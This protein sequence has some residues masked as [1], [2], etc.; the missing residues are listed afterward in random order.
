MTDA[1]ISFA[2]VPIYWR[3]GKVHIA[4]SEDG[5]EIILR[6]TAGEVMIQ[7]AFTPDD[8]MELAAGLAGKARQIKYR[9][10]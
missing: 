4:V 9:V 8:A 2:D 6:M 1:R 3:D 5:A 10:W 7:T